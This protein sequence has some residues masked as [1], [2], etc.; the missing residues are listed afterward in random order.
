[1]L[2]MVSF[3]T[4]LVKSTP[5]YTE[6]LKL[7]VTELDAYAELELKGTNL[8]INKPLSN[9]KG[10]STILKISLWVA[11][12]ETPLNVYRI[13]LPYLPE[14]AILEI[15]YQ[16]D[17]D[18]VSIFREAN[19]VVKTFQEIFPVHFQKLDF[20]DYLENFG[21][22]RFLY[23]STIDFDSFLKVYSEYIP[24]ENGGFL[25]LYDQN[26]Y[27]NSKFSM[28]GIEVY[29]GKEI[30]MRLIHLPPKTTI[31]TVGGEYLASI[32]EAFGYQNLTASPV[33]DYSKIEFYVPSSIV[34]EV[35][36]PNYQVE[37]F[38]KIVGFLDKANVYTDIFIKFTYLPKPQPALS[39]VKYTDSTNW[40]LGDKVKVIVQISNQGIGD[41]TNVQVDDEEGFKA[42]SEMATLI[43]GSI[44]QTFS[45]IPSG[46]S[47]SLTYTV[48]ITKIPEK[49][50][51]EL[52]PATIRYSDC[53][54]LNVYRIYSNSFIVGLNIPTASLIPVVWPER[55]YL[56]PESETPISVYII[57]IGDEPATSVKVNLKTD[58]K[59]SSK[60]IEAIEPGG[61]VNFKFNFTGYGFRSVY[62]LGDLVSVEYINKVY[63]V[64]QLLKIRP[65]ST[66]INIPFSNLPEIKVSRV[67]D[68]SFV[69][70]GDVVTVKEEIS[71][72]KFSELGLTTLY[73]TIPQN[74][75]YLG[76]DYAVKPEKSTVLYKEFN[77]SRMNSKVTLKSKFKVLDFG[78]YVL[79]PTVILVEPPS[80][81]NIIF[82]GKTLT[83]K[84]P[85]L[86]VSKILGKDAI[87][88]GESLSVTLQISNLE[89]Y[90]LKNLK[91]KDSI[92]KE[93]K[94][95]SGE[96]ESLIKE[97]KPH[98]NLTYTYTITSTKIGGYS[99]PPANLT[100]TCEGNQLFYKSNP[101]SKINVVPK[102]IVSKKVDKTEVAVGETVAITVNVVNPTNTRVY[103]V[104]VTDPI[105]AAFELT[106]GS[107]KLFIPKMDPGDVKTLIYEIKAVKEGS[108][109]FLPTA[110]TYKCAGI[111]Q[112]FT[113]FSET[114]TVTI[115]SP[116]LPILITVAVII[117][118][119]ALLV[120]FFFVREKRVK[121]RVKEVEE[122][123][124]EEFI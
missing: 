105:P 38:S 12:T 119:A 7:Y 54:G 17:A 110:V 91:I 5:T 82:Y 14:G 64:S 36:V 88:Q 25:D 18:K 56:E 1:M 33:A 96:L 67:V 19:L 49:N 61:W 13:G 116:I 100:V 102:L 24:K 71:A 99:L 43:E 51:L 113:V 41:A 122:I 84:S 101:I 26:V 104:S 20:T 63:E 77:L 42:I 15:Q 81:L 72:T 120:S 124:E 76:G 66:L 30:A 78:T 48:K 74:L 3:Q 103:E 21:K 108:Y 34:E 9:F 40:K 70:V 65:S 39:V 121:R 57:N 45:K 93:F 75:K 31:K 118:V 83:I 28:L 80:T 16:P 107:N 29:E 68:K 90:S 27:K 37:P 46:S 32:K 50:F 11:K 114:Y 44:N 89:D 4:L 87:I 59:I 97:I 94:V 106:V 10:L 35:V 79:P 85:K 109:A 52:K 6:T 86:V 8:P 98:E 23:Y 115:T 111:P 53:S 73:Q 58:K 47:A 2:L 117:A 60:E 112:S 55:F 95:L 22:D 69:N 123:S 92:P 62:D